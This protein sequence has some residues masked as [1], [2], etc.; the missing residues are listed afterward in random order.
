MSRD[1]LTPNQFSD[2]STE[3]RNKDVKSMASDM[4][5]RLRDVGSK[6]REK[7]A[8]MADAV[9]ETV[10]RQRET[11]AGGLDRVASTIH[12]NAE[13]IPGGRKAANV[14]HSVA[15]GMES[16]ASYLRDHG[17]TD[18]RGDVMSLCR[19]YPTQALI[20]ALAVG[21]LLGRSARR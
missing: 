2:A 21:F 7:T 12:D 10:G 20:S 9:S 6:A 11:A 8:Q 4:Q 5:D 1:P 14:A 17:F 3:E 15:R 16:T 13:S 19:K 18:M